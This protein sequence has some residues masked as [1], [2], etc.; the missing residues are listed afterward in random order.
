MT[1]ARSR[2]RVAASHAVYL[3]VAHLVCL[4]ALAGVCLRALRH[5]EL[6]AFV[7]GRFGRLPP[8]PVP[9]NPIW[10]HAVSVGEVKAARALVAELRRAR[11]DVPLVLSTGTPTGFETARGLFPELYVF[12]A[13]CDLPWVVARA[14]S[15]L[16]PRLIVLLELEVWPTWM[17]LAD[18]A[19]VPQ[20]I[21]NGRMSAKS[22][23]AYRRLRWWL[24]EF[25]R[26]T[27]VAAQDEIVAERLADLGVPRERLTVTG[28][29]KHDLIAEAP[30]ERVELLRAALGLDDGRP[31]FVAGSTHDGEDGPAVAAW[32]AA[33][34]AEAA[35]LLLVP[36]H[37]ERVPAIGRLLDRLG[38]AYV[39]RSATSGSR[40]AGSVL[41]V[42]SMGELEALFGLAD[43]VFLGGT[44]VPVG[45]HNV[46]EPA[47]AGCAL[48]VGPH[49]ETCRREARLLAEAGGLLTVRDE[50][51]LGREVSRLLADRQAAREMG[52]RARRAASG[53]RGAAA[54]DVRLLSDAGLLGQPVLE[55]CVPIG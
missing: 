2:L 54:A 27:L 13:P 43:V 12:P 35:H 33:G 15:R 46:L 19:G 1:T 47:V 50:V 22:Y 44:L 14:L 30:R 40:P 3:V 16:A 55:R 52:A 10:I 41:L 5:R 23:R 26:L 24:P 7:A 36:R 28:N 20:V 48:L 39:L 42:D 49:T 29:L 38:V 11:A 8:G 4:A 34:G 31:V 21:V 18:A 9:P 45:G 6:R 37:L 25:D 32:R 51:G 53:L 17:R